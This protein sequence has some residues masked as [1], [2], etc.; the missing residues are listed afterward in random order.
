MRRAVR[1]V[2]PAALLGAWVALLLVWTGRWQPFSASDETEAKS[3]EEQFRVR[4]AGE[5]RDADGIRDDIG[6]WASDAFGDDS[7]RRQAVLQLAADYQSVLVTT[8]SPEESKAALARLAESVACVQHV[9][10]AGATSLMTEVKAIILD[11]DIRVRAWL[12]AL[13]RW[14]KTG[15]APAVSSAS[16]C[17]FPLDD[18]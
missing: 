13:E 12:K 9:A 17:R 2:L 7:F 15:M 8:A 10:G 5:D 3:I 18:G 14:E 1:I 6:E 4:I 16:T 11:S